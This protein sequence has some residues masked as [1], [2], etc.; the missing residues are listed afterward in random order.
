M[1][2]ATRWLAIVGAVIAVAVLAGIVVTVTAGD[3]DSYPEGSPER[4]VQDYLQAVRDRD[5]TAVV[6]FLAPALAQRCSSAYRDPIINRGTNGLRATL[7]RATTRGETAEVHVR[8]TKSYGG[9]PFGSNESTMTT[10]F[11]L[12]STDGRWLF[13][14]GPWPL[15]CP[16]PVPAR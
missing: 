10:V 1:S 5:A 16:A 14:E 2:A 6:A 13:S 11:I 12:T 9:G 7:D 8:I 15:F 3:A 4:T